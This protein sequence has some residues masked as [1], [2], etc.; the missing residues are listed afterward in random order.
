MKRAIDVLAMIA[1]VA[2]LWIGTVDL[3]SQW[4][5]TSQEPYAQGPGG[6]FTGDKKEFQ[7]QDES[8]QVYTLKH[9]LPFSNVYV[10][11]RDM[12]ET[13]GLVRFPTAG[14]SAEWRWDGQSSK[15]LEVGGTNNFYN[16]PKW[17][18]GMR[19]VIYYPLR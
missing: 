17:T 14:K 7:V 16:Q 15:W 13:N 3:A 12:D 5:R 19:E 1:C 6:W 2:L 10:V 18:N 11:W 4:L 9:Y 8:G